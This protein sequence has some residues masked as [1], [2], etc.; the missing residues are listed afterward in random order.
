MKLH[1]GWNDFGLIKKKKKKNHKAFLWRNKTCHWYFLELKCS[2]FLI[3]FLSYFCSTAFSSLVRFCFVFFII[4]LTN[5][6]QDDKSVQ[7]VSYNEHNVTTCVYVIICNWKWPSGI[8]F[9]Y[10]FN[11]R[12]QQH[13]NWWRSPVHSRVT[14]MPIHKWKKVFGM[15]LSFSGPI[16]ASKIMIWHRSCQRTWQTLQ[17]SFFNFWS[18]KATLYWTGMLCSLTALKLQLK[19]GYM[20]LK[21]NC[22]KR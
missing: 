11:S 16:F 9:N 4:S 13:A 12:W 14:Y 1:W 20:L 15:P 21:K 6:E 18:C 10:C 19:C 5:D 22:T 2:V 8:F 7:L 3:A 17:H